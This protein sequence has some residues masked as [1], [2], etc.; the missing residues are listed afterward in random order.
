M[1]VD[2]KN[3]KIDNGR[4]APLDATGQLTQPARKDMA[5]LLKTQKQNQWAG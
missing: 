1:D 2:N 4:N 3:V 5:N